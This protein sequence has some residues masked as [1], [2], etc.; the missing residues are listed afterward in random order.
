MQ[1]IKKQNNITDNNN[2]K[3]RYASQIKYYNMQC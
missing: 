3:N 1:L 2:N